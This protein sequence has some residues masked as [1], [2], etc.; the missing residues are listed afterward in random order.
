MKDL[1]ISVTNNGA[2]YSGET[3]SDQAD[4]N[5]WIEKASKH[6]VKEDNLSVCFS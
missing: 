4:V 1:V 6:D 2:Q 5:K 3:E